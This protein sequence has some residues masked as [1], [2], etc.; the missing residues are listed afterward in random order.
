MSLRPLLLALTVSLAAL[1]VISLAQAAPDF[2]EIANNVS[3]QISPVTRVITMLAF[4]MG[5][6]FAMIGLLK[7][8]KGAETP[9]DPSSGHTV[10]VIFIFVGAAM[11]AIPALIASGITSI[12]G[13]DATITSSTGGFTLIP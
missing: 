6:V 7:I 12:F 10:G 9:N 5:V 2:G 13:A 3:R 11:V 8:K 4:V 1:P